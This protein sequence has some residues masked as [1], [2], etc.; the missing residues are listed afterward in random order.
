MAPA[1][2]ARKMKKIVDKAGKVV[3]YT[4]NSNDF[5]F[6]RNILIATVPFNGEAVSGHIAEGS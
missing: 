1:G 2:N 6:E 3:S 4:D 5:C